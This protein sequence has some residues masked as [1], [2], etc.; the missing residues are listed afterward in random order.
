MSELPADSSRPSSF[1]VKNAWSY[2]FTP[3]SC[4]CSWRVMTSSARTT[5]AS[6][7]INCIVGDKY[8]VSL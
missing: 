5:C 3:P 2:I 4:V 8:N 6:V 1:K 7:I